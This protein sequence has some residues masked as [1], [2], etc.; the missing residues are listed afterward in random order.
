MGAHAKKHLVFLQGTLGFLGF[1]SFTMENATFP[2]NKTMGI[3]GSQGWV[4]CEGFLWPSPHCKGG[5]SS[6]LR[7]TAMA[8]NVALISLLRIKHASASTS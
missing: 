6:F 5:V 4:S 2:Y 7:A 1:D 3:L 8:S